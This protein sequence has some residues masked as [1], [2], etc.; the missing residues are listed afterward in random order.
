MKVSDVLDEPRGWAQFE[1]HFY[2]NSDSNFRDVNIDNML[3]N[4]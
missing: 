4:G 2:G 1:E 3:M